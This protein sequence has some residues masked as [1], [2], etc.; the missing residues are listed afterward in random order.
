[1]LAEGINAAKKGFRHRPGWQ[2]V[3]SVFYFRYLLSR[4]YPGMG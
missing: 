1:M 4:R 3:M 2:L